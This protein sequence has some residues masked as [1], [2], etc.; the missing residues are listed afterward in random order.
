MELSELAL[1]KLLQLFPELASYIVSFRDLT[2]ESGKE[3]M[4]LSVGMFILKFGPTFYYLPVVAKNGTVFP[5]DSMF[6]AEEGTFVPLTK[7]YMDKIVSE[8]HLQLGESAKTPSTVIKNPSVYDLVTPPRTGKFVYASSSRLVE[9]LA[10]MPNMVKQAM[11]EKFSADKE[12][13]STLH[14]LFGLE[15]LLAALKPT[16]A[17]IAIVPKPAVEL[18]TTGHGLENHVIKDILDKGY[19]LRGEHTTERVAVLAN[20]YSKLGPLHQLGGAD[21]GH[22]YDIVMRNADVRSAYV[23]KRVRGAPKKPALFCSN[24]GTDKRDDVFMIFENGDYVVCDCMVARGEAKDGKDILRN[25]FANRSPLTPK[26]V[27][28]GDKVA[29]FTPDMELIGAYRIDNVVDSIHGVTITGY[30]MTP[31]GSPMGRATINAYRNCTTIETSDESNIFIPINTLMV[32]LGNDISNK[33]EVNVNAAIAKLELGTL[34]ALG[35]AVDMGFD[36]VEFTFAGKP[37]GPEIRMIEVLVAGE[38]IAP[39]KAE[40]FIKQAKE[41]RHIKIYLSKK[42]D[43]EPGE[44]PQFGVNPPEQIN[45]FGADADGAFANNLRASVDTQDPQVIESMV[46][47]ELLQA[48]DMKPM[49]T[50]YLPDIMAAID[51]LGRTLFL[52]RLNIEKLAQSQNSNEVMSF[53]SNL[54]NV[55]RLLGDNAIKLERMASSP[56]ESTEEANSVK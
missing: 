15:N 36:G 52:A 55:Y 46:L 43:F 45:N 31:S 16:A 38:G 50:E 25:L 12:V 4:G 2:Q 42:A 33:I 6:N 19:S 23:P 11:V 30:R 26:T 17:P 18:V 8:S 27:E 20:D 7:A 53:I 51:K 5:I 34:E 56:E 28:V 9:F 39:D 3:E 40:S 41:Q 24:F 22:A 37:I 47:S 14:R 49:V 44:I 35:S 48:T 54:R 10:L 29:V 21:M 1:E 13:Y 32:S